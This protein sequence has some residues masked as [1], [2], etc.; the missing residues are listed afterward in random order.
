MFRYGIIFI[1]LYAAIACQASGKK[2]FPRSRS[3]FI[4]NKGQIIDQ[5]NRPNPAV[6]YLLRDNA[7]SARC[8]RD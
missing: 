6:L 7:F 1:L 2:S 4:E 8:L 3:G 5:K